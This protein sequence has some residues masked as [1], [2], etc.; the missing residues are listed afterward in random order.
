MNVFSQI[1]SCSQFNTSYF[2][3]RNAGPPNNQSTGLTRIIEVHVG[4]LSVHCK[5]FSQLHRSHA[6]KWDYG[7]E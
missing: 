7:Y 2:I 6:V 3:Q 5:T 4:C 1:Q